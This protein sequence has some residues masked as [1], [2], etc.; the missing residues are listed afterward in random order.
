[1]VTQI[2]LNW[3]NIIY[4]VGILS[5]DKTPTFS[6][7]FNWSPIPFYPSCQI[8][9]LHDHFNL[10]NVAP[11]QIYFWA[12]QIENMGLRIFVFS[13]NMKSIRPLKPL[14]LNYFGPSV[15]TE[16]LNFTRLIKTQNKISQKINLLENGKCENYP[17]ASY[18]TYKDC[19]EAFVKKVFKE[20]FKVTPFWIADSFDQVSSTR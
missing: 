8:I 6:S 15:A 14:Y 17:T 20:K 10:T 19:D 13:R 7:H 5:S 3:S 9:D 4:K 16:N 18:K 2:S 12:R 11:L 1:M